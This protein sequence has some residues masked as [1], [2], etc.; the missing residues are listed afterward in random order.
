MTY[1]TNSNQISELM[2]QIAEVEVKRLVEVEEKP[3]EEEEPLDVKMF[4]LT[5]SLTPCVVRSP[6]FP[7]GLI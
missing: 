3:V 1:Y 7:G 6:I 4:I 5:T 2:K